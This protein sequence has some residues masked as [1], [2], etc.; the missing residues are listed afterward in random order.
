MITA[1]ESRLSTKR[2]SIERKHIVTTVEILNS[3]RTME[4]AT[5]RRTTSNRKAKKRGRKMIKEESDDF[6]ED[7][8]SGED[9]NIEIL[10]CIEVKR[11][12]SIDFRVRDAPRPT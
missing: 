8:D 5:K 11:Y 12:S 9:E 4:R 3:M 7:L 2:K 10:A 1:R 6:E